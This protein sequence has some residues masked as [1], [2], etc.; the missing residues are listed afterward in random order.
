MAGPRIPS[1][2]G[3]LS[4]LME[5]ARRVMAI[6]SARL[7]TMAASMMST[8]SPTR[9]SLRSMELRTLTSYGLF[10]VKLAIPVLSTLLLTSSAGRSWGSSLVTLFFRWSPRKDSKALE[11]LTSLSRSRILR[12]QRMSCECCTRRRWFEVS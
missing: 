10:A 9:M 3:T 11:I 6:F 2:S 12:E 4:K 5:R 8:C 1:P 7:K